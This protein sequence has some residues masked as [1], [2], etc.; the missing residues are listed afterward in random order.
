MQDKGHHLEAAFKFPTTTREWH[1]K[2]DEDEDVIKVTTKVENREIHY[3]IPLRNVCC[4]GMSYTF[5]DDEKKL[6]L[7][8]P[9]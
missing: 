4:E 3:R 1:I 5:L 6:T 9:K 7:I 8:F 2:V